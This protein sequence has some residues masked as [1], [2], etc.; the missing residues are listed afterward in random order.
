MGSR[1]PEPSTEQIK[2]DNKSEKHLQSRSS[3]K[4]NRKRSSGEYQSASC[5]DQRK[6]I[7]KIL[8]RADG[9]ALSR[10]NRKINSKM[11]CAEQMK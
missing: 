3:R 6:R 9:I 11:M 8:C 2:W 1:K 4:R 7:H 5:G 10:S